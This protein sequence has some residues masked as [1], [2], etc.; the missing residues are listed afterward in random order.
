[1]STT[2][3][4]VCPPRRFRLETTVRTFIDCMKTSDRGEYIAYGANIVPVG[5][6][7]LALLGIFCKCL[8]F[9]MYGAYEIS[10]VIVSR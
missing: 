4:E 8:M 7:A 3:A 9:L 1:M 2:T 6:K 5:R 10:T